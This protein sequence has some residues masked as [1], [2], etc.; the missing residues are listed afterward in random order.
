M[1]KAIRF[2]LDKKSACFK[3]A[4][5]NVKDNFSKFQAYDHQNLE[6][7]GSDSEP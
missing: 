6:E 4:E 7:S 5:N 2:F 1:L 3:A